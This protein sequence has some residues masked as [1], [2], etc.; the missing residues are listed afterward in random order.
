MHA[1]ER[2]KKCDICG[3]EFRYEFWMFLR[4]F[5]FDW[6]FIETKHFLI[7]YFVFLFSRS[8]SHMTRH[9]RSHTGERPFECEICGQKFSQRYNMKTHSKTHHKIKSEAK[10]FECLIC[11][12]TF[13]RREK[14][15]EHLR[16]V[17]EAVQINAN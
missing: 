13:L 3:S 14:L 10:H 1:D 11:P 7:D 2:S 9:K 8:S 15:N 4:L 17:H 16:Q 12:E 5:S 6:P